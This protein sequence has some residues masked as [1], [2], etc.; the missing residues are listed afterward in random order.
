[1]NTFIVCKTVKCS[2]IV[3]YLLYIR[4]IT[5]NIDALRGRMLSIFGLSICF[6]MFA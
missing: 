3:A 6:D 2:F 4:E 5:P 1:M